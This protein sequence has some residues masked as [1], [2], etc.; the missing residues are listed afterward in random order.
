MPDLPSSPGRSRTAGRTLA[1]LAALIA[2]AGVIAINAVP[3]LPAPHSDALSYLTAALALTE[4]EGLTTPFPA[5]D[6]PGPRTPLSHY[7]PGFPVLIAA[8]V[9]AGLTPV[10]SAVLWLALGAAGAV[11]LATLVLTGAAGPAWGAVGALL[12]CL[13]APLVRL[14]T[15][16][17]SEPVFMALLGALLWLRLRRP[18]AW[19]LQGLV[20]AAGFLVRYLGIALAGVVALWALVEPGSTRERTRRLLAGLGPT[21]LVLGVLRWRS[22]GAEAAVRTF[23]WYGPGDALSTRLAALVRDWWT[24][25][26]SAAVWTGLA[27]LATL[28]LGLLLLRGLRGQGPERPLVAGTLTLAGALGAVVALARVAA[29]PLIPLDGRMLAPVLYTLTLGGTAALAGAWPS[30][31]APLRRALVVL[32]LA[33]AV[34]SFLAIRTGLT[35]V[36]TGGSFY[37]SAFWS[38]SAVLEWARGAEPSLRLFSNEPELLFFQAG[39][40]ARRL[41]S[42]RAPGSLADLAEVFAEAPGAVLVLNPVR[43][44]EPAPEAIMEALGLDVLVHD[45]SGTVLG[46]R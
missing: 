26:G 22:A 10:Q 1:P 13:S 12:L 38:G 32:A 20:A 3:V 33:W 19:A 30:W 15:S 5:W 44:G 8:G 7:P 40:P 39:R 27:T 34:P 25:W 31:P 43:P 14:H 28:L 21:A 2:F 36:R 17:W 42:Y 24:P 6:A 29:D 46:R 35:S 16:I 9:A 45:A 11:G 37:T 41:P 4:G 18:Q 23:R